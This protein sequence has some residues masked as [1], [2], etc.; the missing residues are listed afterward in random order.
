MKHTAIQ[1]QERDSTEYV[2]EEVYP[3][4]IL[5]YDKDKNVCTIT[6]YRLSENGE[7]ENLYVA[8]YGFSNQEDAE[9]YSGL[10]RK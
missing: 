10:T 5:N 2:S 3:W 8:Y 9:E 1:G 6:L 4:A 7:H